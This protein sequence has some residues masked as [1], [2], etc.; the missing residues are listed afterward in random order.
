M[1]WK[2]KSQFKYVNEY[3]VIA[4]KDFFQGFMQFEK[5]NN[6]LLYVH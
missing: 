5:K 3:F 6:C 1:S 4:Y 2:S